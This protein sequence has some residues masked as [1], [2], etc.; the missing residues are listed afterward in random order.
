MNNVIYFFLY[1]FVIVI[2]FGIV[3]STTLHRHSRTEA[4]TTRSSHSVPLSSAPSDFTTPSLTSNATPSIPI[5]ISVVPVNSSS[6]NTTSV[7]S[8]NSSFVS[9]SQAE[10]KKVKMKPRIPLQSA[11]L[12][13]YLEHLKRFSFF[14]LTL[15]LKRANAALTA[16]SFLQK[17]F[18]AEL[19][20]KTQAST[21]C[22]CNFMPALAVPVPSGSA[23]DFTGAIYT[24]PMTSLH[25]TRETSAN[26]QRRTGSRAELSLSQATSES[27][28]QFN[29]E[30]PNLQYASRTI[31]SRTST[32]EPAAVSFIAI[33][34]AS[35]SNLGNDEV[36]TTPRPRVQSTEEQTHSDSVPTSAFRKKK[37]SGLLAEVID[38]ERRVGEWNA[39]D[40]VLLFPGLNSH[41]VGDLLGA[42]GWRHSLKDTL[43]LLS[44]QLQLNASPGRSGQVRTSASTSPAILSS[45]TRAALC[46]TTEYTNRVHRL[47][48][49]EKL[50]DGNHSRVKLLV[51]ELSPL[52]LCL[53]ALAL[54]GVMGLYVRERWLRNRWQREA[55]MERS[56][57]PIALKLLNDCGG[58]LQGE[59]DG[60]GAN[61]ETYRLQ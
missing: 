34:S 41:E 32:S 53:M 1:I 4:Q 42:S 56:E 52:M 10:H 24:Q 30:S 46:G 50:V 28:V 39:S 43:L 19:R 38:L 21:D 44:S 3:M 61:R 2:H 20:R 36:V 33:S 22:E 7:T 31:A 35:G 27:P 60:A 11:F 14:S 17:V 54:L 23:S 37:G 25:T 5:T 13:A 55:N 9:S 18:D 15:H 57:L 49:I 12:Q 58:Q 16:D 45:T 59:L 51:S 40:L 47:N 48:M 8:V 6:V 29:L 26:E